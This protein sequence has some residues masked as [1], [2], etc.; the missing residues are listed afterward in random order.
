MMT[1]MPIDTVDEPLG[2]GLVVEDFRAVEMLR[3]HLA[4]L[5]WAVDYLQLE[6]GQLQARLAFREA[7]GITLARTA[8]S[9][10]VIGS[11]RSPD[12]MFTIAMSASKSALL[13]NGLSLD[14]DELVVIPPKTDIHISS[15]GGGWDVLSVL[16]SVDM[17]AESLETVYDDHSLVETEEITLF[18]LP[19]TV[20]APLRQLVAAGTS[21]P[22]SA[23]THPVEESDLVAKMSRLL[24]RPES[25]KKVGDPYRRLK[26][27]RVVVRAK[28]Y[29]Y[30][31]LRELIHVTDLCKYCGV[32]LSTLERTFMRELGTTPNGYIRA[33]RLHEVR[34]ALLDAN[35]EGLTIADIAMNCGFTHMGRFSRRYRTHFGRLP[36]EERSLVN[37]TS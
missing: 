29:V 13:L 15:V 22:P 30:E 10:R 7:G 33:A 20:L 11:S 35:G 28:E 36:S 25:G 17:L 16:V 23:Q 32:S 5:G 21:R 24:A 19:R 9:H 31:H 26:K 3:E 6:A 14:Q 2:V 8:V 12:D 27:H 4:K 37:G 1:H 18:E 34:H